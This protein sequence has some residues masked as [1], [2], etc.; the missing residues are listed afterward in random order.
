MQLLKFGN[1]EIISS[2]T[3]LDM[4]SLIHTWIQVN[5][6]SKRGPKDKVLIKNI[7]CWTYLVVCWSC[8]DVLATVA[9]VVPMTMGWFGHVGRRHQCLQEFCFAPPIGSPHWWNGCVT[10][11]RKRKDQFCDAQAKIIF[12]ISAEKRCLCLSLLVDLFCNLTKN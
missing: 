7:V 5:P 3:L 1:G 10:W 4:F 2:H 6:F 8:Q 9:T 11:R 12:E